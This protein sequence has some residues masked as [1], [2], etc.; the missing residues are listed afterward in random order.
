MTSV[1]VGQTALAVAS[2]AKAGSVVT[3]TVNGQVVTVQVARDLTVAAGDTVLVQKV[4]SAWFV[5][6]RLWSAA[7][8]AVENPTLPNPKPSFISGELVVPPVE[9]R[10]RASGTWRTD[11]DDVIQGSYGALGTHFGCAFYGTH[12]QSLAGAV[13]TAA[14]VLVLRGAGGPYLA[15]AATLRLVTENTRPANDPTLTSTT[16]GPALHVGDST[17]TFVVPTAWAQAMVDG[18]AGGLAVYVSGG[19]PYLRFAGRGSWSPAWTLVI[20]WQRS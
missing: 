20:S 10:S 6:Q 7:P 19:T 12:P 5:L 2:S 18:T 4:G 13:V 16:T 8:T 1:T 3:A 11:T 9:T 15:P 17:T 14:R